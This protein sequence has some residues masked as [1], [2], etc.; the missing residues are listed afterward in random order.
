MCKFVSAKKV[1][2][3]NENT[4]S[5]IYLG[6]IGAGSK[7]TFV[8]V[9]QLIEKGVNVRVVLSSNSVDLKAFEELRIP[10]HVIKMFDQ[11][12]LAF[13][14]FRFSKIKEIFD[15][16]QISSLVY[17]PMPHPRDNQII[18]YLTKKR[19]TVGRGIHD[20][21]RHPGDIWPNKISLILQRKYSSFLIAHSKFVGNQFPNQK[22]T[23]VTLP[24]LAQSVLYQPV[25]GLIVFIGRLRAYKGLK[26]LLTAWEEVSPLDPSFELSISGSGKLKQ[27]K[28]IK[29]VSIQQKWLTEDEILGLISHANCL[30]FPYIEASQ[31]G[32]LPTIDALHIPLVVTNVGGLVEQVSS[33]SSLVVRPNTLELTQALLKTINEWKPIVSVRTAVANDD[34][35]E[36]L[37]KKVFNEDSLK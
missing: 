8:L 18:R 34:L 27:K 24:R 33:S 36:L 32:L 14:P 7:I 10:I 11:R 23:V 12:S 19:L 2:K 26:M 16:V 13:I 28:S 37:A 4:I 21:A 20:A 5:L 30:V 25:R 35:A 31:S 9:K 1:F 17:F 22:V 6:R 3:V 29:S 15:F